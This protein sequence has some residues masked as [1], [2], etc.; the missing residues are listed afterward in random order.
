MEPTG[1][2]ET[3]AINY[4]Y[5]LSNNPGRSSSH[6]LYDK[7]LK[8]S[9]KTKFQSP[10]GKDYSLQSDWIIIKV[11]RQ[12]HLCIH[13]HQ[14]N[15]FL[16]N[17]QL[18]NSGMLEQLTHENTN[19]KIFTITFCITIIHYLTA[20]LVRWF[21]AK[22]KCKCWIISLKNPSEALEDK[23]I[24]VRTRLGKLLLAMFLSMTEPMKC[25]YLGKWPHSRLL[26]NNIPHLPEHKIHI[27]EFI[28]QNIRYIFL[29]SSADNGGSIYN[30]AYT[31]SVYIFSWKQKIVM[32]CNL[33]CRVILHSDKHGIFFLK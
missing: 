3:S 11:K 28:Y 27:P 9:T 23:V 14:I 30:C 32:G 6:L 16:Q 1:C 2:A 17:S 21:L 20:L 18:H 4:Q 15:F 10:H 7:S 22:T 19:K 5:L 26:C 8:S 25:M 12:N 33:I 13:F 29:N 24:I 31:F